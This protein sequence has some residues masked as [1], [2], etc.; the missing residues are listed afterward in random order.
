MTPAS[1]TRPPVRKE[2]RIDA[3]AA[4]RWL[5]FVLWA[6]VIA[7][8]FL[9]FCYLTADFP[10]ESPWLIDQA[11]FTDEGW[12]SSAAVSH[13]LTGHWFVPGDYN[14][15]VALPVWPALLSLLFHFTGVSIVAARALNVTISVATLAVVFLLV[16][17]FARPNSE[18]PALLAAV[19]LSASPFAF[20][21]NRLAILDTAVVFEFSCC[22]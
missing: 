2:A 13:A 9:K 5:R 18:V 11:K 1:S 16:R 21:F 12:W 19:L 20:A 22:S 6:I 15:A 17:R 8:A 14:P 4:N 7:L 3:L 10:N